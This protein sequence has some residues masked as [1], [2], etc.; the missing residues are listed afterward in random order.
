MHL[1]RYTKRVFPWRLLLPGVLLVLC[2]AASAQQWS[3]SVETIDPNGGTFSGLAIDNEGNV[4]VGYMSPDGGGTKYAFRSAATGRW[5]NMLVD[6]SNGSVNIAL[7][8]EG[9]PQLCYFRYQALKYARWDGS[10]WQIQEIAPG[11]GERDFL[12]GI[13]VGADDVPHV[14]WYQVK[15]YS[16]QLYAHVRYAAL[17]DGVWRARTLDYGFSTGKWSCVRVDDKGEVHISYS[18]FADRALRYAHEDAKGK[19]SIQTIEDGKLGRKTTTTPG[20]GNS[21]VLDKNGRPNFS[22]RDETTLRYAWPEG[23][24]WRIDVVDPNVNPSGSMDW[25]S[26]RTSLALDA[27]GR[28]H[29]AYETDGALKHAWW[30]GTQWRIQS[31]GIAGPQ[32]RYPALAISKDNVMYITYSDPQDGALKILIA[33]PV[34]SQHASAEMPGKK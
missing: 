14:T 16:D 18:A 28:P 15:D 7:D 12:C 25:I 30:D 27:N 13:A 34:D 8:H 3:W 17:K 6:K 32:H 22:Y 31:L 4:H 26:Q 19:W 11:S 24:H 33:R 5:F 10:R 23:D 1:A 20:M 21:M 29:I 2:C 9:R